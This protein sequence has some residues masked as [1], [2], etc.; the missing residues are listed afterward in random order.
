[1]KIKVCGLKEPENM[2]AID[3]LEPDFLGII[4]YEKSP[5]FF[6]QNIIPNTVGKKVGV[7]V[8]ENV[9]VIENNAKKYDLDY[10]Q[11]HGSE[12][13][14]MVKAL[15]QKGFKII[16]AFSI[17][18]KIDNDLLSH[19][20]PF[21]RYFLFDTKGKNAG[22]NGVKFDWNVLIDYTLSLPFFLSGGIQPNDVAALKEIEHP[23]L[24]AI[25]INSGFEITA[26]IKD[27]ELV[28]Q[29]IHE[30][31]SSKTQTT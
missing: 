24:A 10:I 15:Y 23:A 7:F 9:E 20:E 27:T 31:R 17:E 22:G 25:D 11:L 18:E 29:F 16:K 3:A 8:N 21:C 2:L 5:R 30:I 14:E 1:M 28:K 26:G 12:P 13:V 6:T 19:Y 4:F